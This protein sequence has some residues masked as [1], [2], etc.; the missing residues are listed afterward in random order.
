M[1]A[2]VETPLQNHRENVRNQAPPEE[3][4]RLR[5]QTAMVRCLRRFLK[6][7]NARNVHTKMIRQINPNAT[8]GTT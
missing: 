3:S 4:R 2:G 7:W 5:I 6:N 1:R 8:P